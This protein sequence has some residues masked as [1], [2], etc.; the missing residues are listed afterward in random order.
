MSERFFRPD[1]RAG[2]IVFLEG[3][4]AIHLVRVMR[5]HVGDV[6]VLFDGRGREFDAE[7]VEKRATKVAVRL[8]SCRE[9]PRMPPHGVTIAVTVPKGHRM[10]HL[11]ELC[12]AFGVSRLIP[13]D[14]ARSVASALRAGEGKKERWRRIAVETAKQCGRNVLMDITPMAFADVL[15]G[16]EPNALKLIATKS[17]GARSAR[18]VLPAGAPVVAL[19]G[20]EGG[21]TAEEL[22]RALA[23]GFAPVELGE[24]TLRIEHAAAA[25]AA[26]AA[27]GVNR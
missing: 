26:L 1:C 7:V 20:P 2:E 19:V 13:M 8:G 23:A 25:L 4:E 22:A 17:G 24:A 16:C 18:E 6:V 15:A 14:T 12:A 10:D 11:V 27:L 3:K 5:A 21:F 9:V